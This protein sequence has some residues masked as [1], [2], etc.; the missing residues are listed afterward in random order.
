M[1]FVKPT[2]LYSNLISPHRIIAGSCHANL[3]FMTLQLPDGRSIRFYSVDKQS[4]F[5]NDGA[6]A[7]TSRE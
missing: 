5:E 4:S 6:L 7:A 3:H 1:A 2:T